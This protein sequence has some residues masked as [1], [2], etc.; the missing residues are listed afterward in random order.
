M[1]KITIGLIAMLAALMLT[2]GAVAAQGNN[3]TDGHDEAPVNGTAADWGDWMEQQM[4]EH[5][6]ADETERMQERMGVSY[7]QMGAM[8]KGMMGDDGMRG[9]MGGNGSG[10]GCH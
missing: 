9:M 1:R 7:E 10:M 2:T 6:G 3:T 5:M 8:M 4:T